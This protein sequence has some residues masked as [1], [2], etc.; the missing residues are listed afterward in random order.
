MYERYKLRDEIR[1][2]NLEN[3]L[4]IL[5]LL[6]HKNIIKLYDHIHG[7]RME[8]LIMENGPQKMLNDFSK[9]YHHQK[10]LEYE[11]KIIFQQIVEAVDYLHDINIIHRDLK[12]QNI[13]INEK[14]EI[15]LI[16]FGF[17]NFY[18]KKKKF[19]VYCGTPSYMAPE[20]ACRIP[21]DG[22]ASDVWSLGVLLYI[23]LTGD[24]PF[25]GE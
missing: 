9:N 10:I 15:K 21:Y 22:K 2:E 24:F 6:D 1:S 8:F 16:D 19:N 12:M 14:F 4:K 17:A 11:A 7:E 25:K 13:L 3:E 20:L 5:K 23:M 18:N